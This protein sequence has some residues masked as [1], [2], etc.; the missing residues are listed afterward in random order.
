MCRHFPCFCFGL[1]VNKGN[2]LEILIFDELD[3]D[4]FLRLNLQHLQRE[5]EEGS[6]LDVSAINS[7]DIL[8]LHGFVNNQLSCGQQDM[9]TRD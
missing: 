3:D 9:H 2:S 6:G 5:A 4:V 1:L 7:T 8:Q